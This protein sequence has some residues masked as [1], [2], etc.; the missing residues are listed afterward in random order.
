MTQ[1]TSNHHTSPHGARNIRFSK[2][3]QKL[4]PAKKKLD[5]QRKNLQI[6]GGHRLTSSLKLK[7]N[8]IT[9]DHEKGHIVDFQTF[10]KAIAL[11]RSRKKVMGKFQ[12]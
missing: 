6:K 4:A 10:L 8:Q 7:H 2:K 11:F 12:F 9:F 1:Q 3:L 5:E